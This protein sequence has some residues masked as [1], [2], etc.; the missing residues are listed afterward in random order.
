[1]SAAKGIAPVKASIAKTEH[2]HLPLPGGK[3][4]GEVRDVAAVLEKMKV[5][6]VSA[7]NG[8][9]RNAQLYAAH[10]QAIRDHAAERA[11]AEYLAGGSDA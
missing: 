10:L 5:P 7:A 8:R 2:D 1:M 11:V 4:F 9:A 3:R 6:G